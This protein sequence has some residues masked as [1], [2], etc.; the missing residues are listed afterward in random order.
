MSLPNILT[1][2]R[3]GVAPLLAFAVLSEPVPWFAASL[4]VWAAL[5]DFLDGVIARA[6]G[7]TSG[8]GAILDPIADKIFILTA[9]LLLLADGILRGVHAW[10]VLIVVWRELLISDLRDSAR[11]QGFGAPVSSLAKFKTALQFSSAIVLFASR[12]SS[13][14]SE[15]L[16]DGGIGLLWAAAGLTLYTG[17]VYIWHAWRKTWT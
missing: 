4:V 13:R 14:Y 3:I 17:A 9:L 1:A 5:S 2:S 8:L 15:V 11:L 12:V 16:S 6:S 10:A 7:Q